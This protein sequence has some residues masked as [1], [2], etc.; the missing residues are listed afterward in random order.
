MPSRNIV[1]VYVENGV[2]H[3]YNRGV[4]KREIFSDEQ[5]YAMF[6]YYL[7][8][9]FSNPKFLDKIPRHLKYTLYNTN[10]YQEIKL[11]AFCLMPNHFHL[12]VKQ[13]DR[14]AIQKIMKRLGDAYVRYYNDK[15]ERVGSLFQGTYKAVLVRT[16][17]QIT[18]LSRYI[19]CNPLKE[20]FQNSQKLKKYN[21]SSYPYY[22]GHKKA[23]WLSINEILDY[24]G[25]DKSDLKVK[26]EN[27]EKF[28]DEYLLDIEKQKES[29]V[30][31]EE[32]LLEV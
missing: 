13:V 5:D 2:Y 32:Y 24:F 20:I 7:K 4:D 14:I 19:H 23:D 27:Y 11:L 12:L 29:T 17:E 18:H 25:S 22:L 3:I 15:Y 9:Y 28:I 30:V 16:D 6:L 10:L 8:C 21:F 1:K 31:L 26:M